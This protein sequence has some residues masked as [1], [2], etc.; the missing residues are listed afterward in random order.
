M[1]IEVGPGSDIANLLAM[2]NKHGQDGDIVLI[3]SNGTEYVPQGYEM[4]DNTKTY[5]T[6]NVAV[7][8]WRDIRRRPRRGTND[9]LNL[10]FIVP[11]GTRLDHLLFN[12][13]RLGFFENVIVEPP[14][15][16]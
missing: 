1:K 10:I 2:A 3:D 16:R 13:E 15:M 5:I 12:S 8:R 11:V 4:K 9:I 7:P 6:F 14:S